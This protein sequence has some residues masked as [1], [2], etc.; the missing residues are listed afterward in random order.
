MINGGSVY[1]IVILPLSDLLMFS[2]HS[3]TSYREAIAAAA[4][5]FN[6]TFNIVIVDFIV[7]MVI[8]RNITVSS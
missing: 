8:L 2:L 7:R 6:G 1:C 3:Y 4:L 5:S